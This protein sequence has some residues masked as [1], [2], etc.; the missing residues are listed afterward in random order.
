MKRGNC[1][2]SARLVEYAAV[3]Q[4][5]EGERKRIHPV[6]QPVPNQ[7]GCPLPRATP[8]AVPDGRT[9]VKAQG[10]SLLNRAGDVLLSR[11][12]AD[13]NTRQ[14]HP[15]KWKSEGG[16]ILAAYASPPQF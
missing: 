14:A 1:L 13:G 8:R 12:N 4:R 6:T 3:H 15:E 10:V 16:A 11:A 9:A 7:V 2:T 5:V